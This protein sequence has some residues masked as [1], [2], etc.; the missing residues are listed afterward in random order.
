M[1]CGYLTAIS[2]AGSDGRKSLW[3]VKCDCG[4]VITM[5]ASEFLKGKQKSCGCKRKK[6]ISARNTRH[7]MSNTPIWNV[8]HSMVERCTVPTAQAW[9]NYGGRGIKV[10]EEWMTFENFYQDMKDGYRHGLTLDRIDVNGPYCKSNCRW[11]TMKGQARNKRNT[12]WINTPMGK[13]KAAEAADISGIGYT[14]LLYRVEH[15]WP[16]DLLF[17]EPDVKNRPM[18]S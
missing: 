13:M 10:S 15:G 7:G 18:T 16:A 5:P 14:T 9:K 2:Y 4:N 6:L 12:K 17:M 11:I 8:W 3:I 1:R